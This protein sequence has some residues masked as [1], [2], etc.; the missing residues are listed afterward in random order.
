M[1]ANA[2]DH[3]VRVLRPKWYTVAQVAELLGYGESKVRSLIL[4]GDLRSLKD[5]RSRRVLPEWVD[6]Y[7]A[8]RAAE[9]EQAWW[10]S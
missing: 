5:G 4:A 6:E 10:T 3:E 9:A 8:M 2:V 1:T 7:V